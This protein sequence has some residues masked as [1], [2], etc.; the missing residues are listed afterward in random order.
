MNPLKFDSFEYQLEMIMDEFS[1]YYDRM[2]ASFIV[3]GI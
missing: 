3:G 2:I 1:V